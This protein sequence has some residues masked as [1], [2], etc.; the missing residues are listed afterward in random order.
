M[1]IFVHSL[2]Q[3]IMNRT[4][5]DAPTNSSP[6]YDP[7]TKFPSE[8]EQRNVADFQRQLAEERREFANHA[9]SL[10]RQ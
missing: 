9:R 1:P 5:H 6:N 10:G 8:G 7:K 4:K 3:N 2:A